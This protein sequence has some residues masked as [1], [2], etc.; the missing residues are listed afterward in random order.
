MAGVKKLMI[1]LTLPYPP[2]INNY[3]FK[4]RILKKSGRDYRQRVIDLLADK[5]F[6]TLEGR[7]EFNVNVY[8]PDKRKRDL[9]NIQKALKDSLTHAKVWED[10]EQVDRLVVT[11]CGIDR[12]NGRVE[13][14]IKEL[15]SGN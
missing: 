9:D 13:V 10:D 3:Y 11:R 6:T 12:P 7:L 14:E 15:N 5:N 1:K 2:T 8:T 4:G